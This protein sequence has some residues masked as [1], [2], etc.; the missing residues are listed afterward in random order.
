MASIGSPAPKVSERSPFLYALFRKANGRSWLFNSLSRITPRNVYKRACLSASLG[1]HSRK[2]SGRNSRRAY[3]KQAFASDS[4]KLLCR[5]KKTR[6]A[7]STT[8]LHLALLEKGDF[9][10]QRPC[11]EKS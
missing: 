10:T 7:P 6:L 8:C 4:S 3:V 5:F 1:I 9:W 11:A 2:P